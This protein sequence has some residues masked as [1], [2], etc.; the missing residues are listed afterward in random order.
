MPYYQ[1]TPSDV[2]D[3]I[4]VAVS[5]GNSAGASSPAVSAETEEVITGTCR[6][7]REASRGTI[8]GWGD[9][10]KYELGNGGTT[11]SLVPTES[12]LAGMSQVTPTGFAVGPSG[13]VYGWGQYCGPGFTATS[14]DRS[15]PGVV[16]GLTGVHAVALAG[17]A[18]NYALSADGR[19]FAWGTNESGELGDGT[20][21]DNYTP[22][23]VSGLPTI[24][25]IAT[26][27][28]TALAL[29]A[30]DNVYAWGQNTGGQL[31]IGTTENSS[32]P[33]QVSG[34]THIVAIAAGGGTEYALR[35]DGTVY[36]WG[37]NTFGQLGNGTAN[38]IVALTPMQI[39][40][41][42][43]VTA[44]SAGYDSTYALLASGEVYAWGLNAHGELGTGSNSWDNPTPEKVGGLP[45]IATVDGGYSDAFAVSS[46]GALYSWGWNESGQLGDGSMEHTATPTL[47]PGLSDVRAIAGEASV[48]LAVVG[49]PE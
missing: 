7:A 21:T 34:L 24:T 14:T 15:S 19:I 41:L 6:P 48:T 17:W 43:H 29:A 33:V 38:P 25:A 3:T 20:K 23:E 2:H 8:Y 18:A 39:P 30:N 22:R 16:L 9:N 27:D 26:G 5:A 44:V 1:T 12:C 46:A 32:V 35:A 47:V 31:G 13:T 37:D 4:R 10:K 28:E 49:S 45:A 40:T 36:A 42:T 11:S